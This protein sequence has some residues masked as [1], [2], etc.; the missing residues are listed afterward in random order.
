MKRILTIV[1][2]ALTAAYL[3]AQ[4]KEPHLVFDAESFDFGKIKQEVPATHKFEFTNTGSMPV[5]ISDVKASCG[6]TTPGWS[7][8]P[9]LPRCV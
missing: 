3:P 7:K 9:V 8:E 1:L 2:I 6:C 5:I 4:Q